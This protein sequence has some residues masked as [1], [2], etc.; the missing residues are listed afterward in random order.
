MRLVP[1]VLALT[2]LFPVSV[3]AQRGGRGGGNS[4][5][6]KKQ[7]APPSSPSQSP[8]TEPN[9]AYPLKVK[10]LQAEHQTTT[11]YTVTVKTVGSGNV[12][13]DHVLGFDY[14]TSCP[15]GLETG[16]YQAKW[17]KQDKKI[18]LLTLIQGK[19][20]S[21]TCAFDVEMKTA[22][23]ADPSAAAAPAAN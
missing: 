17:K 3:V 1:I 23:Y 5:S 7:E 18:E 16:T 6:K 14:K 11:A 9:A 20:K 8:Y 22:P 10:L 21:S 4:S 12:L 15:G 19:T 13:G 2:V